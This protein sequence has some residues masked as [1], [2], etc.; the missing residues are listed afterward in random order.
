M[1][2]TRDSSDPSGEPEMNTDNPDTT[3]ADLAYL[4]SLVD[5]G[6]RTQ[7]MTGF[8]LAAGGVLYG[9]QTLV[10]WASAVHLI[11]LPDPVNFLMV[12][13]VTTLFL[14]LLSVALWRDRGRPQGGVAN[15]AVNAAFASAG[16][17]NL[18]MI[19]VFGMTAV[20]YHN[21]VI[22]EL[23]PAVVFALQGA[24]WLVAFVLRRRAWLGVVGVGWLLS[25]AS[26]GLVIDTP[27][28]PL[29]VG[30]ALILLLA[31]PGFVLMRLARAEPA[32]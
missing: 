17:A 32:A 16:M 15:K 8:L 19:C 7:K 22:W 23:Y 3:Q 24:A 30:I 26:L 21:F 31:V 25:A 13:G 28:Y 5:T 6:A 2:G 10:Q 4:R 29:V 18:S 11:K 1:L 12:V 27:T 14:V 20:R 9:L